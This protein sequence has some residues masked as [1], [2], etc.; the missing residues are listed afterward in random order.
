MTDTSGAS[1]DRTPPNAAPLHGELVGWPCQDCRHLDLNVGLVC[2]AFPQGIPDPILARNHWHREPFP[3]DHGIQYEPIPAQETDDDLRYV[4]VYDG[5]ALEPVGYLWAGMD[6]SGGFW[7]T[8]SDVD[9][10]A[11]WRQRC[12]DA[13]RLGHTP[14]DL[15][16]YWVETGSRGYLESVSR[17]RSQ[18]GTAGW[19]PKVTVTPVT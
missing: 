2:N 5:P 17:V 19:P 12:R 9:A 14:A 11:K 18:R 1:P 6:G 16:D 13:W 3:G 8:G 7:P 4:I 15:L 10:H